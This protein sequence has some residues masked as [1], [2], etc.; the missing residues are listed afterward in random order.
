MIDLDDMYDLVEVDNDLDTAL[1]TETIYGSG[2]GD[3]NTPGSSINTLPIEVL[4]R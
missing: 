3:D 4:E 1:S 2:H